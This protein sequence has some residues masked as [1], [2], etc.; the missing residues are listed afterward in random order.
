MASQKK[1]LFAVRLKVSDAYSRDNTPVPAEQYWAVFPDRAAAEEYARQLHEEFVRTREPFSHP[2]GRYPF[3][4][5]EDLTTLPEFAFRDWLT[6][7]GIEPPAIVPATDPEPYRSPWMSDRDWADMQ[8][9]WAKRWAELTPERRQQEREDFTTNLNRQ[10]WGNWWDQVVAE[11]TLTPQQLAHLWKGLNKVAFFE[12]VKVSSGGI[13]VD[14]KIVFAVVHEHW[15]YDDC[16]YCGSND[17]LAAFPSRAAAEA[18]LLRQQHALG[19]DGEF[20]NGGP[21]RL[22]VIELPLLPEG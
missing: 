1:G 12:V 9:Q 3:G 6:E 11:G 18:E 21:N 15:E 20:G 8:N 13:P 4:R 19:A 5:L 7:A 14:M 10:A 16:H 2:P 17:A 22:V